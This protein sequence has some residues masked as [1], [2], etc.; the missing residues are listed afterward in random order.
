MRLIDLKNHLTGNGVVHYNRVP[1]D[2]KKDIYMDSITGRVLSIPI[3][4]ENVPDSLVR[5]I[6][7]YFEIEH[8]TAV[9]GQKL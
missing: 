4:Q 2:Y 9:C 6:C 5:F 8:P 7:L 1:P 3:D